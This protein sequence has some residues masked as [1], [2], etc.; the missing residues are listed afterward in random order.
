ME[1]WLV[2]LIQANLEDCMPKI[3]E[4][5]RRIVNSDNDLGLLAEIA[6]PRMAV[7]VTTDTKIAFS[8]AVRNILG[9]AN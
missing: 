9:R 7:N 1:N 8:K 3:I 2:S 6:L 4:V 5:A